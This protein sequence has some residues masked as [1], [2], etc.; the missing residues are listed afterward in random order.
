MAFNWSSGLQFP[1]AGMTLGYS[2]GLSALLRTGLIKQLG[3]R[4]VVDL[5]VK[6]RFFMTGKWVPIRNA[7]DSESH[8]FVLLTIE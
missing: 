6:E 1:S 7:Q 2:S 3:V 5:R 4:P 8:Y